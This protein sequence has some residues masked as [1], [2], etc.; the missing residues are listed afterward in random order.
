MLSFSDDLHILSAYVNFFLGIKGT[1]YAFPPT[2]LT[3]LQ[4]SI[5]VLE[6][7]LCPFSL[8]V[9]NMLFFPN[10]RSKFYAYKGY[11]TLGGLLLCFHFL[12]NLYDAS[13]KKI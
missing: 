10:S 4:L 11:F 2:N 7:K 9:L 5:L 6:K 12:F 3:W 13:Y 1:A 8:L